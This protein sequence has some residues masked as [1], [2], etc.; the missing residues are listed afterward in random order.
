MKK[1]LLRLLILFL[2]ISCKESPYPGYSL[3]KHNICIKLIT[4]GDENKTAKPTDFVTVDIAYRTMNDSLFFSGRRKF[5]LSKP[6]YRGSVDECLS[7]LSKGDSAS[8]IMQADSFFIITLQSNLPSFLPEGSN[9]K[10]DVKMVDVQTL[11]EYN[12]E[13]EAFLEWIEDFGNYEKVLLKQYIEEAKINVA[14]TSTGLYYIKIKEGKGKQVEVGDTVVIHYEG[15][16]LNGKFFDSTKKRNE[17]FE[18]VY[19]QT[20]QVI[21]GLEEA[22]GKMHE[23]EKAIVIM[24]SEIGF[25][26]KGSSTG[27]IPPFTSL[28][29]EVELIQLREGLKK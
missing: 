25:G 12:R 8:F 21:K 16:F 3:R 23:G 24:P 27:I 9:F 1:L 15:R 6:A 22:I 5:Q 7:L 4:I 28:I 29:F 2:V 10:L 19:G 18:F 17:P 13:K 14:P 11:K 26:P 20:W